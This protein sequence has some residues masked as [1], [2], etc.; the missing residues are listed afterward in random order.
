[1]PQFLRPGRHA[2]ARDPDAGGP[3]GEERAPQ[4]YEPPAGYAAHYGIQFRREPSG[5]G[6]RVKD[7]HAAADRGLSGSAGALPHLDVVQRSFGRHDVGGIE[8]HVGGPATEA[9]RNM[10]AIAYASGDAVAFAG[11]PDLHTAAHEAAH[12]IQQRAGVQLKNG[13]GDAGDEHEQHADRVADRVVRGE[14]AETLLDGY[15]GGGGSTTGGSTQREVLQRRR[16][17]RGVQRA[18]GPNPPKELHANNPQAH[19]EWPAF[20]ARMAALGVDGG[21]T[22]ALWTEA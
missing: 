9:A 8:A 18:G 19:R 11:P 12:V 13:V 15:A 22:L 4:R 1:M 10:G 16:A 5:A 17:D 6:E 3:P 21:T 20:S 2:G 7:V 14:S